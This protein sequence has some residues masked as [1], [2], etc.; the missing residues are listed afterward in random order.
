MIEYLTRTK[1]LWSLF[2]GTVLFFVAFGL[3]TPSV[4]G[5]IL[6]TV[7]PVDDVNALLAGMSEAQKA[8][9]FWMTLLLDL[10]FPFVYGG[11]FVGLVFRHG[12]K[13]ARWLTL[14]ALGAM[15][16]DLG[17]NTIQLMALR[18]NESLLGVKA[19]LTPAKTGLFLVAA[20]IATLATVLGVLRARRRPP[21]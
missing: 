13:F 11:L 5:T 1:V 3:W 2:L 8:S 4:G 19:V 18:D 17:E 21:H 12:G 7:G 14:P 6:D 20:L 10:V 16:T 15:V 9:H